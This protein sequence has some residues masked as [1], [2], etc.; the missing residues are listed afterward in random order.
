M[1][2]FEYASADDPVITELHQTIQQGWPASKAKVPNA[3][4]PYYELTTEGHLV[5]KGPL[6]VVPATLRKEMM[7]ACHE[8][9]IGLEGCVRPARE[10]LFWPRMVT[11]LKE[12]ISK[13]DVCLTH[14]ATPQK[15]TLKIHEFT[16][17]PWSK[18]GADLCDLHGRT[19]LVV[20]DYFSNFVEVEHLKTTT[21]RAVCKALKVLFACYGVP[22]VLLSD[23]GP[24]FA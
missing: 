22:D 15:E 23:N 24:Q 20:C 12:Y 3:L 16:P 4:R 21:S 8:T 7:A 5:F 19:L 10:S 17:R 18:V 1:Q 6:I 2:Q 14:R 13:C 11:E 9:H